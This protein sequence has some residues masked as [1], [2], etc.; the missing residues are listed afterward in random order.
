MK[1]IVFFFVLIVFIPGVALAHFTDNGDG[2]VTDTLTGLIW[3]QKTDDGGS[4]DKDNEYTWEQALEYYKNL[5]LGG[6]SDWRL[7]NIKE[8]G[9]I[10]I[11]SLANSRMRFFDTNY[12]PGTKLLYWSSATDTTSVLRAWVLVF[13]SGENIHTADKDEH[14]YVRAVRGGQPGALGYSIILK[15][16]VVEEGGHGDFIPLKGATVKLGPI[17]PFKGLRDELDAIKLT[18]VTDSQGEFRFDNLSPGIATVTA[19]KAGH[20][21]YSLA[22][23]LEPGVL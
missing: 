16:L 4:R 9:S 20:Q 22:R 10:R 19:S 1:K 18:A 21:P 2:T 23:L 6:H 17:E 5:T 7:P 13:W 3:E 12:F 11:N 8:L 14:C 15:G